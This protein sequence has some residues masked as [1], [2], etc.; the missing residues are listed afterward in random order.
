MVNVI[1]RLKDTKILKNRLP[2]KFETALKT[3]GEYSIVYA[4]EKIQLEKIRPQQA[5]YKEGN[6]FEFIG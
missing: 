2:E 5:G 1:E 4:Q 3:R 6:L